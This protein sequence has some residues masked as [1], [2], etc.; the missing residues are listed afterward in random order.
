MDA[1]P[2]DRTRR[3]ITGT[4]L[5]GAA[6]APVAG[7]AL[8]GCGKGGAGDGTAPGPSDSVPGPLPGPKS[9]P[10]P[11]IVYRSRRPGIL[12][13]GGGPADPA[14]LDD[15]LGSA[16]ASVAGE[17]SAV[18]GFR[19]L[20]SPRD[21]VGIKINA[22][23]GRAMSARPEV[24]SRI[25]RW[26]QAAGVPARQVVIFERDE[27]E[28]LR[29]GFP[30]NHGG[31]GVRVIGAD[32]DYTFWRRDWGPNS[33]R[34]TRILADEMTALINVGVLKDGGE[35]GVAVGMKNWYGVIHNPQQCH[36]DGCHPFIAHLAAYPLI[37]DKLRLTIVD[38]LTAQCHG[39]PML[40]PRWTWNWSGF[41]ASTDPVAL[42]AVAWQV[43]E[44]R[45][46]EVGLPTLA[47]EGRAPKW[48]AEGARIG[49]GQADLAKVAIEDV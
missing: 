33:S 12:P 8:T 41:L 34:F 38:G 44:A 46:Q 49:L 22:L 30:P 19:R 11:A 26:L 48:I 35:A 18:D 5:L 36:D 28:L 31:S 17:A 40:S 2:V 25:T 39:G 45:R 23:A 6:A 37:R 43:L 27:R 9:A 14:L 47:A 4:L 1:R 7:L 10:S 32:G 24:V 42:D 21:V 29:A 3:R 13:A 15:A 20:F 16:V